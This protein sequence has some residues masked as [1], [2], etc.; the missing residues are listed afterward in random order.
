MEKFLQ[1]SKQDC[2]GGEFVWK[3]TSVCL[4][5]S[6]RL[7]CVCVLLGREEVVWSTRQG[8]G[9]GLLLGAK[10]GL[11][12]REDYEKAGAGS[13][14][15]DTDATAQNCSWPWWWQR[16]RQW[17]RQNKC[18]DKHKSKALQETADEEK[19]STKYYFWCSL[20]QTHNASQFPRLNLQW[21]WLSDLSWNRL[22]ITHR[23]RRSPEA[24]SIASDLPFDYMM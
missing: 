8:A 24:T 1:H 9:T 20:S 12:Q 23:S 18:Q 16:Q 3:N 14:Q 4:A 6:G 17:Q 10:G 7:H 2:T 5:R 11:L 19:C 21:C 15:G 13:L 22:E